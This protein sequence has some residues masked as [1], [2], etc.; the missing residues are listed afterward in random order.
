MPERHE[1]QLDAGHH[2]AQSHQTDLLDGVTG[3]ERLLLP[4]LPRT[5]LGAAGLVDQMPAGVQSLPDRPQG[6]LPLGVIEE[7]LRD[8]AGQHRQIVPRQ[9]GVGQFTAMPVHLLGSRLAAGH[10]Q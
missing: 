9:R 3:L 8:V 10:V 6:G 5:V 4:A 2:T 7:H 1:R